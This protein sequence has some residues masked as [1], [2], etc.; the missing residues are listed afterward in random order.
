VRFSVAGA[1]AAMGVRV[2]TVEMLNCGSAPYP[3]HGYPS[4]RLLDE[5]RKPLEVTLAPGSASIATVPGFDAPPR[6]MVLR[7]GERARTALLWRNSVTDSGVAARTAFHLEAAATAGEP[8]RPVPARRARRR[9]HRPRHH[10]EAR[11]AGLAQGVA[12]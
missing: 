2:L 3:V 9:P 5:E 12:R 11:G 4:V 1:D 7:P 6:A 8:R 10:R